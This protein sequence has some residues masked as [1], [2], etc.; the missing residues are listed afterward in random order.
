MAHIKESISYFQKQMAC[1][2]LSSK[3]LVITYLKRIQQYDQ[4]G[5]KIN[6]IAELN[7]DA[8]A[9][10]KHST[11]NVLYMVPEVPFMVFRFF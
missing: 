2:L 10:S 5:P 7:P 3:E 1:G 6:S 11:E 9:I 4:N 8:I